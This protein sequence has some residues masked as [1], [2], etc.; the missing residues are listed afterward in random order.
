MYYPIAALALLGL[1][2]AWRRRER[3]LVLAVVAL[4][5]ASAVVFTTDAM[6]RYRAP[7]E[8]L[9]VVLAVSAVAGIFRSRADAGPEE[10][11]PPSG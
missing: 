10:A 4:G 1:L 3:S 7:L 8:P 6:T 2:Q 11:A 9:L 5:V